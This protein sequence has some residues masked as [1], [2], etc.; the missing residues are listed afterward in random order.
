QLQLGHH[1]LE[2]RIRSVPAGRSE[3]T[4]TF[5]IP[6]RTVPSN[7]DRFFLGRALHRTRAGPSGAN[8]QTCTAERIA[9]GFGSEKT[10]TRRNSRN[11]APAGPP[12]GR[13][14]PPSK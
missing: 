7:R 14:R 9:E 8:C 5:S 12:P 3:L 10:R 6:G 11:A 13:S 1:L 2:R 4:T